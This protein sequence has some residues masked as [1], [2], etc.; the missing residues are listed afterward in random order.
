MWDSNPAEN[1]VGPKGGRS[2]SRRQP[3]R[4]TGGQKNHES[5]DPVDTP[6][7]Q[8]YAVAISS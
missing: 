6:A 5:R 7:N 3:V 1:L 8:S 2:D 4:D